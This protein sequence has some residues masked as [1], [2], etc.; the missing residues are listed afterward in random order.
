MELVLSMVALASFIAMVVAWAAV[1]HP[2]EVQRA[3]Y[4]APEPGTTQVVS[5]N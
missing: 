3:R 4:Q 5:L 2:G 1:P